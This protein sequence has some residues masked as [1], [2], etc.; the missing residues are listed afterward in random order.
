MQ[1]SDD[2][3]F[4]AMVIDRL[5]LVLFSLLNGASLLIILQAPVL[6]DTRE[7]LAIPIPDKPLG[8]DSFLARQYQWHLRQSV[9]IGS[10]VFI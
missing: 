6:Y 5:F 3:T 8:Q 2:W 7:P 4:V 1:I 10:D 9:M